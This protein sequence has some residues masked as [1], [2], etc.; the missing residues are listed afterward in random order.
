MSKK[1]IEFGTF[2]G[3]ILAKK[4]NRGEVPEFT[5]V[6]MQRKG[7]GILAARMEFPAFMQGPVEKIS[8]SGIV[9]RGN[10]GRYSTSQFIPW[11]FIETRELVIVRRPVKG[12]IDQHIITASALMDPRRL[13]RSK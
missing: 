12:I 7:S 4:I 8:N 10:E 13:G 6:A 9:L 5:V 11:E 1:N 2:V 3:Q